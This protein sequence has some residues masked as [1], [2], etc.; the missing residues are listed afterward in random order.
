MINHECVLLCF[1]LWRR[2]T[3][4]L[5]WRRRQAARRSSMFVAM[6][7]LESP[8]FLQTSIGFVYGEPMHVA[9]D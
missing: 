7:K 2:G 6:H 8:S 1:V 3:P 9:L 4:C 5:A